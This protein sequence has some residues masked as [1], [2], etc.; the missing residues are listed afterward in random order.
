MKR[1]IYPFL[2]RSDAQSFKPVILVTGCGSGIGRALA[3]KLYDI[4]NYR[5]VITARTGSLASLRAEFKESDRFWI[6]Q[7]DVTNP[8][9]R[10]AL[11]AEIR[12]EWEGVNILIN[13]AGIAYRSVLEHMAEADELRQMDTNYF[14]PAALIRLALPYMRKIGRGKI[15]NISS[16]SGMLAMPTMASYSASKHA[17]E[18]MSE[19]L[20]YEVRPLG[21]NV[22]LIQPGFVR[23]SSF[24]KVYFSRKSD[25]EI[26]RRD[27][28]YQDYY[29]NMAPFIERLMRLSRATP[30]LLADLVVRVIQ[31]EDPPLWIPATVDAVAFSLLRRWLPHRLLLALLFSLLPGARRWALPYTNSRRRRA[32]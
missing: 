11:F 20:W 26:D 27:V 10:E 7:L 23:S 19:A 29:E 17:L 25:P 9:Q 24:E 21:I 3:E 30:E 14:G 28:T 5:V 1:W 18:G 31:T 12:S 6:R 13:N 16:V 8:K 4:E 15:I 32:A 2:R 22:S